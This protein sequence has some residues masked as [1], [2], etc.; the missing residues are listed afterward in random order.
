[1]MPAYKDNS[2]VNCNDA[3]MITLVEHFVR[4]YRCRGHISL[5]TR[6]IWFDQVPK[7][8]RVEFGIELADYFD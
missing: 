1:M 2:R 4:K 3:D 8:R 7:D 5:K 6:Q